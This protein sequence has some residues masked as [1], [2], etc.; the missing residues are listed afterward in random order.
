[1]LLPYP[2]SPSATL[3]LQSVIFFTTESSLKSPRKQALVVCPVGTGGT[4]L[5]THLPF[6]KCS[7][8]LQFGGGGGGGVTDFV[9]LYAIMKPVTFDLDIATSLMLLYFPSV[10]LPIAF[11]IASL[12]FLSLFDLANVPVNGTDVI[13]PITRI[14]ISPT[15]NS[16]CM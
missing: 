2:M 15:V 16:F 11:I 5:G 8:G 10:A 12:A 14:A 6:S 9:L 13:R 1:M 7:S 4:G 3:T